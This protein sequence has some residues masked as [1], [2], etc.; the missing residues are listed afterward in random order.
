MTF[1][2]HPRVS[3]GA[4]RQ[5]ILGKTCVMVTAPGSVVSDDFQKPLS[6]KDKKHQQQ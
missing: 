6:R 4:T 2:S 5:L 3:K 1:G